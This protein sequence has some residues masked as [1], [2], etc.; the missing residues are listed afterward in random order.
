M[1]FMIFVAFVPER[2]SPNIDPA[3]RWELRY[4]SARSVSAGST[5]VA[6]RAG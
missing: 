2:H 3:V 4:A 6:R 5:R 1:V